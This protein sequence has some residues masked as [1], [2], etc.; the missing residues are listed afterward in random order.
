[1]S[2]MFQEIW[3]ETC[4]VCLEEREVYFKNECKCTSLVCSSCF[5]HLKK[6]PFCRHHFS[7]TPFSVSEQNISMFM[8]PNMTMFTPIPGVFSS[9][10][11]SRRDARKARDNW[12]Y[13]FRRFD[14]RIIM[15]PHLSTGLMFNHDVVHRL[16]N[17]GRFDSLDEA[18]ICLDLCQAYTFVRQQLER[19]LHNQGAWNI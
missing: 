5:Q 14:G 10:S 2:K 9:S 11:L 3:I 17:T 7:V 8:E 19:F 13:W 16:L 6:C 12:N 18:G 1:M 4:G 15:R